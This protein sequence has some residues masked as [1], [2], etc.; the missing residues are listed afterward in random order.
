MSKFYISFS[1]VVFLFLPSI[2]SQEKEVG[3]DGDGAD[4][5]TSPV[6]T[7]IKAKAEDSI[8]KIGWRLM[9]EVDGKVIYE[10]QLRQRIEG[11]AGDWR[12]EAETAK[13]Y[14]LV[15]GLKANIVYDV[16]VRG[17]IGGKAGKWKIHENAFKTS[18]EQGDGEGREDGEQDRDEDGEG[19]DRDGDEVGE[20]GD[21]ADESTSP[22]ITWIKAKAEDSIAKIGWRLMREVDGKVIYE[23]QLRQRIEGKAGDW[24]HEAE[25]AKTYVLVDGLKAN[26]V[27]DVRVRGWIGGKAGKWKIHENAFKTSSEQGDGEGRE[28]R[29]ED[30]EREGDEGDKDRD[31]DRD[32]E[33]GDG[34]QVGDES[35]DKERGS[36]D[37]GQVTGKPGEIKAGEVGEH[38]AIIWWSKPEKP[39]NAEFFYDVQLRKRIKGKPTEWKHAVETARNEVVLKEL[40]SG[41]LYE[42]HVRAWVNKKPSQWRIWEEA[43]LTKDEPD[44]EEEEA[45]IPEISEIRADD[46][47]SRAGAAKWKLTREMDA[48]VAYDVQIRTRIKGKA[49]E[50]KHEA[51][52][53]NNSIFIDG[54][55]PDTIYEIRV[56][57]W[58]NKKP[59]E[60]KI[61]EEAF[62]TR[63]EEG[64]GDD[65]G[66]EVGGDDGEGEKGDR[67]VD[68]D[69]D[70]RDRIK[71]IQMECKIVSG[72]KMRLS[73]PVSNEQNVLGEQYVLESMDS[74]NSS[75]DNS[76]WKPSWTVV[77]RTKDKW[78]LDIPIKKT[79]MKFFRVRKF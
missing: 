21:G 29:D 46:I 48:K 20:D 60:W 36:D 66:D 3:E 59:G 43:F 6:I 17:W 51:E 77:F 30:G 47:G 61:L 76:K 45:R 1:I 62:R 50:W 79:G 23:V 37:E 78:V 16:R 35:G 69:G 4:E 72:N 31:G 26:I 34:E 27:Y 54:L 73:W 2:L 10:V 58:A 42:V 11:K 7:W 64:D 52:T 49:G 8:A 18:S 13:T 70:K 56:R 9:R 44:Q 68:G 22:V 71:T 75:K 5:S 38:S 63:K 25:T 41:T 12:H 57:P 15:D 14:V 24:R 32:D 67:V 74:L 40:V 55:E 33:G 19:G 53:T 28:D 65:N 39:K